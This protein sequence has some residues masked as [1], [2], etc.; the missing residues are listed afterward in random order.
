LDN[1]GS[2][3][4][5]QNSGLKE[6]GSKN[7]SPPTKKRKLD[8]RTSFENS[9]YMSALSEES[10]FAP[11][12]YGIMYS[13]LQFE[14]L[15]C[16]SC[17]NNDLINGNEINCLRNNILPINDFYVAEYLVIRH[18]LKVVFDV[19][20]RHFYH[21]SDQRLKY[22]IKEF[23]GAIKTLL[24]LD[25]KCFRWKNSEPVSDPIFGLIAQEVQKVAPSLVKEGEDGY[26]SVDYAQIIAIIIAATKQML[27]DV[28]VSKDE[29]RGTLRRY[30]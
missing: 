19:V 24:Q 7:N 1:E 28:H 18:N 10:S 2:R 30:F 8:Q 16:A 27:S 22:D 14:N 25:P 11:S 3:D 29:Q 20:A 13:E 15:T 26:L 9:S 5:T 23:N 21:T 4:Y 17:G 12:T 6:P